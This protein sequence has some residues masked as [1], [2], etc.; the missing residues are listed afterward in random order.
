[1]IDDS[2]QKNDYEQASLL[3]KRH[4]CPGLATNVEYQ[5]R[6]VGVGGLIVSWAFVRARGA[7]ARE[8]CSFIVFFTCAQKW[9]VVLNTEK[10]DTMYARS[11]TIPWRSLLNQT[12][13]PQHGR[14]PPFR[15]LVIAI[16]CPV[17]Q[18]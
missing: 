7:R 13:Y 3:Q 2:T 4:S 11:G 8:P 1:M 14:S 16:H 17:L 6:I 10:H 5:R 18:I 9:A 15:V 12:L